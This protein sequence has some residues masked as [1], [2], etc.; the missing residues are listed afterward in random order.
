M[1][2]TELSLQ[3]RMTVTVTN[4]SLSDTK[5]HP[6]CTKIHIEKLSENHE[7]RSRVNTKHQNSKNILEKRIEKR[8]I[9]DNLM[10]RKKQE[11]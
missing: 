6:T 7:N 4:G 3:G 2:M 11:A 9:G 10:V 1:T 8:I 5:E